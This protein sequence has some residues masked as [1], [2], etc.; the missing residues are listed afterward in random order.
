MST[1][2][3]LLIIL[4]LAFLIETLIEFLF[5]TIAGFFPRWKPEPE[6]RKSII[7]LCAIGAGLA[8]AFLFHFDV[9]F[10]AGQE[11][12][13]KDI[14][15]TPYGMAITGIAIGKGSNYIHQIISR[16]FPAGGQK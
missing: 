10:L 5:G 8:G 14:P 9:L 3:V 2:A 7:Q 15:L 13:L 6:T 16:F 1:L 11:A 12:E 4:L